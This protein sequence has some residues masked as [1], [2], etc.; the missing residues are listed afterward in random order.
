MKHSRVRTMQAMIS[1]T[2]KNNAGAKA[3]AQIAN[4]SLYCVPGDRIQAFGRFIEEDH[5]G[6]VQGAPRDFPAADHGGEIFAHQRVAHVG[7]IHKLER[8]AHAPFA[9]D[10]QYQVHSRRDSRVLMAGQLAVRRQKLRAMADAT[11]DLSG[12]RA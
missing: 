11:A 4:V 1:E 10:P 12:L 8:L 9:L 6:G 2:V 7:E 3:L 5:G